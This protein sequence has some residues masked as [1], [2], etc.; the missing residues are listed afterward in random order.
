MASGQDFANPDFRSYA[1]GVGEFLQKP[2][3]LAIFRRNDI[4][5]LHSGRKRLFR[6]PRTREFAGRGWRT[7]AINNQDEFST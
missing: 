2:G 6:K 1:T 3:V 4:N 5:M 7:F